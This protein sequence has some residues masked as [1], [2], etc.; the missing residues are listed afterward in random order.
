MVAKAA[1]DGYTVLVY[2][3]L[4]SAHALHDKLPYDTLND[5]IPVAS[6]GQQILVII[7]RPPRATRR[8]AIS[9]PPRRPSPAR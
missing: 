8:S 6:L 3:A 1:P 5:L 2:G 4:A 7:G 9:S